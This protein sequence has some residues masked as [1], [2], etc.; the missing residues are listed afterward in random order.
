MGR[1]E[2]KGGLRLAERGA[3]YPRFVTSR[4]ERLEIAIFVLALVAVVASWAINGFE[5]DWL[6]LY[7]GLATMVIPISWFLRKKAKSL[8][9][10][11]DGG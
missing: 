7:A 1:D 6:Y 3:N 5:G 4:S 2:R 10:R 9:G 11:A 8:P